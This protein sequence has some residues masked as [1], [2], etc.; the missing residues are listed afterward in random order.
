MS[1]AV[2]VF[3]TPSPRVR[4]VAVDRPWTW[5]AS[6]W[7][8]LLSSPGLSLTVG[9]GV[10]GI[11]IV[12]SLLVLLSGYLY[13]L[14][15]LTAGFFFVAP[16]IA[17]GLYE[18]SR[19]HESGRTTTTVQDA[20]LAC[21]RNGSQIA[22]MG[23]ILMLLHLAWVRI[24]TLLFALFFHGTNLSLDS[25]VEAIFF[26]PISLP[27][28]VTGGLIGLVLA[29]IAFAISAVSIPMLLDRDINVFTAI[30]T[31]WVAVR[32]NWPAM[33]LWAAL[34]VVFTILGLLTF[35]VGLAVTVPL[36]AHATWHAYRDVV[37]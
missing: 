30:A 14:L 33:A 27:F 28:L 9:A 2:P 19:Q 7:R 5:L 31:S 25:W 37:E 15:P 32:T 8:D 23:L 1:D 11:S 16:V 35:N 12:L 21:R 10:A 6:G 26:S 13:L 36:V 17:V 3:T 29:V 18:I 20:F 34:I 24:A 4:A 22:L